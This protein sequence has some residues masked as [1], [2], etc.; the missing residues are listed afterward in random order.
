MIIVLYQSKTWHSK[1]V[2]QNGIQR[3]ETNPQE[4]K[5]SRN[6]A[7]KKLISIE[8]YLVLFVLGMQ[9]KY[10]HEVRSGITINI[11]LI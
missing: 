4:I 8:K 7:L 2:K 6:N 5:G 10:F 11:I 3:L 9:M 1:A